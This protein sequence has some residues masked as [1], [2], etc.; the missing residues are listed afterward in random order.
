VTGVVVW[1]PPDTAD[2]SL[3]H[4]PP[5]VEVRRIPKDGGIPDHPGRGDVVIPHVRRSVLRTLLER[6]DGLRVVQ[7]LSAGV[8]R[9]VDIV[10]AGVTLC[11]AAGVHDI[12]VAE[13]VLAAML[14]MQRDLPHYVVQQ[15][16]AQWQPIEAP[17]RE[18]NGM[19][20]LVVGYGSIG[21]AVG[22]RLRA[23]GA[24]VTGVA[25]H[26]G[27][28]A[29]GP[30]PAAGAGPAP[31]PRL[32]PA[33]DAVVV[34]LPLTDATRGM[35]NADFI[36]RMKPGALLV[37][38]GRGAVADTEAITDAVQQGRIRA[39]LDVVEPEP[40]PAEHPLWSAPGTLITP[41]VAGSSEVFLDRAWRFAGEQVLRYV[42]GE[43]L[44]NVVDEG[45]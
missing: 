10:P 17:A 40:L 12:P 18:V 32:L 1:V 14:A 33:A 37:N 11:D 39:A 34:L 25:L 44:R 3:R 29:A 6:L 30:G 5:G 27:G 13:W 21:R 36:A 22:E 20:V 15:R 4:M 28:G 23:L 19:R 45:Y 31:P 2:D 38:A 7:T 42:R 41:H 26:A 43:P 16:E 9:F 8:D 35:V 24:E